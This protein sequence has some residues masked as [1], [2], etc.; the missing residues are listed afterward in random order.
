MTTA[1]IHHH[2]GTSYVRIDALPAAEQARFFAWIFRQTRPVIPTELD[3]DGQ[4]AACA[5]AW[6][7][8]RWRAEDKPVCLA[9]PYDT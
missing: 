4:S 9:D 1:Q 2:A 5:Y 7:Y 8:A 3:T 6:D